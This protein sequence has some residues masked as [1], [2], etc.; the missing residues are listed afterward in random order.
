LKDLSLLKFPQ[1]IA[2]V[3]P[4]ANDI[5]F[6]N[7]DF[8]TV[9]GPSRRKQDIAKGLITEAGSNPVFPTYGSLLPDI[10]GSRDTP[11]L[12]GQIQ[13]GVIQLLAFLDRVDKSTR[14]DE[15]IKNIAQLTVE[16]D[17][18]DQRAKNIVLSVRLGNGQIVTTSMQ[19]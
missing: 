11:E 14:Q 18:G 12:N 16:T 8:V 13:G 4:V 9:E 17:K 10:P 5:E 2:P 6:F 7:H 19:A 15:K 1:Y 3:N